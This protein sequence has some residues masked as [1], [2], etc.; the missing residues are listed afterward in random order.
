M[1]ETLLGKLG[2]LCSGPHSIYPPSGCPGLLPL[3]LA[4]SQEK[5]GRHTRSPE[6]RLLTHTQLLCFI[7]FA[8]ESHKHSPG[9]RF[10]KMDFAYLWK[11]LPSLPIAK[12]EVG[13]AGYICSLPQKPVTLLSK[14]CFSVGSLIWEEGK[15]SFQH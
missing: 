12:G 9:S 14:K 7:L 2:W 10:G 6:A 4:V 13:S 11:K 15:N 8:K 1:S 5:E 3:W